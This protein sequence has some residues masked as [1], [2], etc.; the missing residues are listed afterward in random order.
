[1]VQW[2]IALFLNDI[3]IEPR[4]IPELFRK[5]WSDFIFGAVVQATDKNA[6]A[7]NPM[8]LTVRPQHMLRRWGKRE[9]E[10]F[11]RCRRFDY[12]LKYR[13]ENIEMALDHPE[14]GAVTVFD[15]THNLL[16]LEAAGIKGLENVG[17]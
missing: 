7:G 11:G 4:S 15:L 3:G 13:R 5:Y 2:L 6:R 12:G 1:V 8:L 10:F 14:D 16:K 9:V 17:S